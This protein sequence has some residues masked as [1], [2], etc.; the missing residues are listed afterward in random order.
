M[1]I[2]LT[3]ATAELF[4]EDR[5]VEFDLPSGWRVPCVGEHVVTPNGKDRT[6]YKV[7]WHA[8][9]SAEVHVYVE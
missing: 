1:K 7:V 4:T 8:P 9:P 3:D 2:Y 5:R 6:V